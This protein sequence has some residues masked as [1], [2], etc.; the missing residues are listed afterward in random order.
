MVVDD[1]RVEI[2]RETHAKLAADP[3]SYTQMEAQGMAYAAKILGID[4]NE[5]Q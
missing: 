2:L 3:N 4:L 1:L 5:E